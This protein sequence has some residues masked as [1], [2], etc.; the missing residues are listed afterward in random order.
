MYIY[1]YIYIN[2]GVCTS[3]VLYCNCNLNVSLEFRAIEARRARRA[4]EV[5][6]WRPLG[7]SL[8][9]FRSGSETVNVNAYYKREKM[10]EPLGS[11]WKS[12][13]LRGI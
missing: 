1:K 4:E 8:T 2:I 9:A 7:C 10:R 5:L 11:T 6:G 3:L 13:G 12:A